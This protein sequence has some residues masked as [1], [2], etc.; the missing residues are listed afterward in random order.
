MRLKQNHG[1]RAASAYPVLEEGDPIAVINLLDANAV[2]IVT[3]KL[4]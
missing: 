4:H 2:K 1:L 3:E